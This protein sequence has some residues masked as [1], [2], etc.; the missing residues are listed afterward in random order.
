MTK[1]APP[2]RKPAPQ[3]CP[4]TENARRALVSRMMS[5]RGK[6]RY[7]RVAEELGFDLDKV[8]AE[9]ADA[10]AAIETAGVPATVDYGT[11]YDWIQ[12][13]TLR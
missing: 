4:L 9:L 10:E 12:S 11:L 3:G 8:R 5:A 6:L 7:S 1:H 13:G 2:A